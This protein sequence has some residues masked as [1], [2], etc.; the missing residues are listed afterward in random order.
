MSV[1]NEK[2]EAETGRLR[3]PPLSFPVG[4]TALLICC[5][6]WALAYLPRKSL[7]SV[8]LGNVLTSVPDC[9]EKGLASA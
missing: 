9:P 8:G 6:H 1:V 4:E 3:F 2:G 7:E 5:I